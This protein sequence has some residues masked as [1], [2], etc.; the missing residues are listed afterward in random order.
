MKGSN[1][2]YTWLNFELQ[3]SSGDTMGRLTSPP[4]EQ[5]MQSADHNRS[6]LDM[7]RARVG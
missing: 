6:S 7:M 2:L 1:N 4:L 3:R 5:P